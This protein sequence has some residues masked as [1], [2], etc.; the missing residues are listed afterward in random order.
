MSHA[1]PPTTPQAHPPHGK[2]PAALT[3]TRCQC[4]CWRFGWLAWPTPE[5]S[6]HELASRIRHT[7]HTLSQANHTLRTNLR[8]LMTW[9]RLRLGL[10]LRSML[11]LRLESDP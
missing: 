1:Q 3:R 10:R 5:L 4:W 2:P 8:I 7:Q 6:A 9:R 11:G